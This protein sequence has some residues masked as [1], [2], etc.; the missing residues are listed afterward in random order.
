MSAADRRVYVHIDGLSEGSG[1]VFDARS[2]GYSVNT[3]ST[4]WISIST[5]TKGSSAVGK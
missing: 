2:D 3:E 1:S 4:Q 5:G